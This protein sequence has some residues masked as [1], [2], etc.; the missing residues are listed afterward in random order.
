MPF[1]GLFGKRIPWRQC[2]NTLE[3]SCGRQRNMRRL[4]FGWRFSREYVS[5]GGSAW[6][7]N[8]SNARNRAAGSRVMFVVRET[9]FFSGTQRTIVFRKEERNNLGQ[10][11]P[12][13]GGGRCNYGSRALR[14]KVFLFLYG[15]ED[16]SKGLPYSRHPFGSG[17]MVG[18]FGSGT[19]INGQVTDLAGSA[20]SAFAWHVACIEMH[21]ICDS[22]MIWVALN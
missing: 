5:A 7:E 6:L 19:T 4:E 13:V 17:A 20:A 3:G 18:S 2:G 12:A 9:C 14:G 8:M 10:N 15:G 21:N 1:K 16:M 22:L 11:A